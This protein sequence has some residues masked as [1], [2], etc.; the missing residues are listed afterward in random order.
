ML[1]LLIAL[2]TPFDGRVGAHFPKDD[3]FITSFNCDWIPPIKLDP[4]DI[5]IRE[6]GTYGMDDYIIT[7]QY[8]SRHYAHIFSIPLHPIASN[9]PYFE[10]SYIW[11]VLP[12]TA[13]TCTSDESTCRISE[14]MV[15]LSQQ[16][17]K[18]MEGSVRYIKYLASI[19][20]NTIQS[21]YQNVQDVSPEP[22]ALLIDK[23]DSCFVRLSTL[24]ATRNTTLY[25]YTE[26][27]HAWLKLAG[28]YG[29]Y[30]GLRDRVL[31]PAFSIHTP[32]ER[33]MGAF[34]AEDT[35]SMIC[36]LRAGVPVWCIQSYGSF[37]KQHI[38]NIIQPEQ[39]TAATASAY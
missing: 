26:F 36:L 33:V 22:I 23:L 6:D 39:S 19:T 28:W 18:R 37:S 27:R 30:H 7:P 12:E 38:H 24:G 20:I 2:A 9:D 29:W 16:H 32:I 17:L 3:K 13:L 14:P 15:Q 5:F 1:I 25:R 34:V 10:H 8:L 21:R 4:H 31:N 11:D 35:D